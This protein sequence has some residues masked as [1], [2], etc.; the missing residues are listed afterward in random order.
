MHRK[1]RKN[2][3]FGLKK[4]HLTLVSEWEYYLFI[5]LIG[6]QKKIANSI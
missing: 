3:S 6:K 4:Y 5:Y 2:T 1:M